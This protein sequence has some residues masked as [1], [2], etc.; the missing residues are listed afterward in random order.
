[1][2]YSREV[3]ERA[4]ALAAQTNARAASEELKIPYATMLYWIKASKGK[5]P[6]NVQPDKGNDMEIGAQSETEYGM[7]AAKSLTRMPKAPTGITVEERVRALE[8][9]NADLK[10]EV[11]RLKNA[12]GVL[13]A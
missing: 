8:K 6:E 4:M 1:M 7:R 10:H 11:Q 9:E 5:T 12:I 2:R 13:I 3:K